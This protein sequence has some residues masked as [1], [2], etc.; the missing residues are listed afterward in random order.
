ML[1]YLWDEV[2]QREDEAYVRSADDVLFEQ[3]MF[4]HPV[5]WKLNDV[6]LIGSREG[7]HETAPLVHIAQFLALAVA[8]AV[9]G[10]R[11]EY[12]MPGSGERILIRRRGSTEIDLIR[13]GRPACSALLGDVAGMVGQFA[14]EVLD[15]VE[16]SHPDV[17]SNPNW[18]KVS[19]RVKQAL[20]TLQDVAPR[21]IDLLE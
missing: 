18:C 11:A 7:E 9:T 8:E 20:K 2:T 5:R 14:T 4:V 13:N 10:G 3:T 12:S 21:S 1:E 19:L 16:R 15:V 6:V 17:L